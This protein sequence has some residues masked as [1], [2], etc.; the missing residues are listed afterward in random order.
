MWAGSACHPVGNAHVALNQG[1]M[2]N[3]RL[4]SVLSART[5]SSVNQSRFFWIDCFEH[6][7]RIPLIAE[8]KE[9]LQ[10]RE[11]APIGKATPSSLNFG[12]KDCPWIGPMI[13]LDLMGC[14]CYPQFVHLC[15]N[16]SSSCIVWIEAIE[17]HLIG[18]DMV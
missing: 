15:I 16:M 2:E 1:V 10:V 9:L 13:L 6:R 8:I 17:T 11:G 7:D 14:I 5:G 4:Q 12:H 3:E 18:R